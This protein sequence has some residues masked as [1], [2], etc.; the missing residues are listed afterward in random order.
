MNA[1]RAQWAETESDTLQVST[2]FPARF[3]PGTVGSDVVGLLVRIG[4]GPE[5]GNPSLWEID[6]GQFWIP[7]RLAYPEGLPLLPGLNRIEVRPVLVSGEVGGVISALVRQVGTAPTAP[8]AP[9][10]ITCQRRSESVL[11]EVECPLDPAIQSVRFYVSTASPQEGGEMTLLASGVRPR[12]EAGPEQTFGSLQGQVGIR[13]GSVEMIA[14]FTEEDVNLGKIDLGENDFP[15]R[16]DVQSQRRPGRYLARYEHDRTTATIATLL[17]SIPPDLPLWYGASLVYETA[18]GEVE[19]PLSETVSSAPLTAIPTG[20]VTI[21]SPS[22]EVI[23][24]RIA[25]AVLE[26][27]PDLDVKPGSFWD[28]AFLAPISAEIGRVRFILDFVH[29]ARSART[30]LQID[31]PD[32]TGQSVPVD[33][34]PYKR[35]LR[36][37]LY[38]SGSSQTQQ[39]I[40]LAFEAVASNVGVSRRPGTR[41]SGA[42]QIQIQSRSRP[43]TPIQIGAGTRI[44][45]GSR[46]YLATIPGTIDPVGSSLDPTT[47]TYRVEIRAEAEQVGVGQN[48]SQ[49]EV[50]VVEGQPESIS[51]TAI[52]DLLGTPADSNLTLTERVERAIASVD[53]G[54]ISGYERVTAATSGVAQSFLVAPPNPSY[55]RG[56]GGL[57]VWV[58]GGGEPIER[59]ETFVFESKNLIGAEAI[60]VGDPGR[61]RFQLIGAEDETPILYLLDDIPRQLGVRNESHGYWFNL[62]GAQIVGPDL[63]EL[64]PNLNDSGMVNQSDLIR[65]SA[66]IRVAQTYRPDRQPILDLVRLEGEQTGLVD[67]SRY[68]LDQ[69]AFPLDQGRSVR[70]G[71]ELVLFPPAP[72]ES[73]GVQIPS[74]SVVGEAHVILDQPEP[75][76]RLGIDPTTIVVR[77]PAS[78][79]IFRGPLDPVPPGG[80]GPDWD[81]ILPDTDRVPIQVVFSRTGAIRVGDSVLIDYRFDQNFVLRY[82]YD[83]LVN[84]VQAELDQTRHAD[85]DPLAKQILEVPVD[86]AMTV[87]LKKSPNRPVS[88]GKIES[89]ILTNLSQLFL[90]KQPGEAVRQSEVTGSV[91]SVTEVSYLVQPLTQMGVGEGAVLLEEPLQPSGWVPIPQWSGPGYTAYLSGQVRARPVPG[92]GTMLDPVRIEQGTVPIQTFYT[93]PNLE[94]EPYRSSI[95]SAYLIG[96][97]GIPIPGL[98]FHAGAESAPPLDSQ[99]NQTRADLTGG[100]VLLFSKTPPGEVSVTYRTGK[101]DRVSSDIDMGPFEKAM[102]GQVQILYDQEG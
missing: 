49:G 35:A 64:D 47:G 95:P 65:A 19:G 69:S 14:R 99:R 31:D 43:Q 18:L 57:D 45:F 77:D 2:T 36:D 72:G 61:L 54:T 86:L 5:T 15:V 38:L 94:G 62:T 79:Q 11:I 21:P 83:G 32:L 55:R 51:A 1:W 68:G 67:P 53:T 60:L 25:S 4:T 71:N 10:G 48:V 90:A 42:I 16:I 17:G 13:S 75:L 26:R 88:V 58:W 100:R 92:G 20:P 9:T 29:R 7:N 76:G 33:S 87:V 8:P 52:Q 97:E 34:S 93:A 82:H 27:Q 30:L 6:Q 37:A 66:R 24:G 59:S 12:E 101:P 46:A 3:L 63:F 80:A 73:P 91:G 98:T 89:R 56:P 39:V 78:G 41:A 102:L 74:L 96:P 84:S 85:S 22:R 70:A 23:S 50:G 81:L 44:L 40:D 28:D